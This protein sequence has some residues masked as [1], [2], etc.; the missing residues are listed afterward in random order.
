MR[1]LFSTA[2]L[3]IVRGLPAYADQWRNDG[4]L[5]IFAI[6]RAAKGGGIHILFCGFCLGIKLT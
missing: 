1:L 3:T 6:R 4:K 5:P 2:R